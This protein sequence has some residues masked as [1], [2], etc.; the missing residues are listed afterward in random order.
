MNFNNISS[1]S[2][3]NPIPIVLL[4]IVLTVAGTLSYFRLPTNN[5]PN[6]DLPVV[7]VSVVQ[8]GAA[9]TELETQVTRLVEDAVAGLGEVDDIN[10]TISDSVSTTSITFNLGV[11]LEKATNDVRNAIAGIR[12][13]LPAD[14][15]E[16]IVQRIEF[17]QLP[18]A[19]YV[20]RAPG[21]NPEELSWFVDNTVAKRML[22]IEGVSQV[23]RDG[24][25]AREIRI[26]LDPE[27]LAAQG[28]SAAAVSNQLRASNINLPGGRGEIGGTE[29]AIRTLGSAP[30]VEALRETLIPVAGRSVRLGD[31]GEISDEWSE[32]RGRARF[33]GEEVV[34]FSVS[35]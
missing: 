22:S 9:P 17:T 34:G 16:P 4:F 24:G 33:N 19:T 32:A 25:V 27:K 5:F 8:S 7:A 26:K 15:Q 20:V 13:N 14:V 35:R 11:D 6:V 23:S 3:R 21:M 29:Q 1:W 12:Q 31:L 10:S 28:V 2:I 18:I 30:S